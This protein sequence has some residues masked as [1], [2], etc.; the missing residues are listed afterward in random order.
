ML[1]KKNRNARDYSST[2]LGRSEF[3]LTLSHKYILYFI[4]TQGYIKGSN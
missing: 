3:N 4:K 2:P 1:D